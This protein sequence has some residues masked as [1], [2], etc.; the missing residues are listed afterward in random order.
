MS[1]ASKFL[2]EFDIENPN[3]SGQGYSASHKDNPYHKLLT[4]FGFKYSHS[5]PVISRMV[6]TGLYLHHTYKNG[7]NNSCHQYKAACC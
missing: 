4:E 6:T 2:D 5:T 1:K 3:S 7:Y